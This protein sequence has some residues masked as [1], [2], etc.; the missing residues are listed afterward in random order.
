LRSRAIIDLDDPF[1]RVWLMRQVLLHGLSED[2]RQLDLDEVEQDLEAL[3]L[4]PDLHRLCKDYL[5]SR[6]ERN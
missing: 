1:Q 4:P 3:D 2:I 5:E 6:H